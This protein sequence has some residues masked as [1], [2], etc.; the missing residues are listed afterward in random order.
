MKKRL[1]LMV[2][3]TSAFIL[4]ACSSPHWYKKGVSPRD[5]RSYYQEC[6]YNVGMNKVSAKKERELLKA[7]M[8]KEGFRWV[9]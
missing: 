6:I 3:A 1:C 2:I 7:C 5:T 4:S 8:E 9:N